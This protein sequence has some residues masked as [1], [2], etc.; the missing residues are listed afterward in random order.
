VNRTGTFSTA[1]IAGTLLA[2][3]AMA[4]V[5]LTSIVS[6]SGG[7]TATTGIVASVATGG[8]TNTVNGTV[9]AS[10]INLAQ[11][12]T[13]TGILVGARVG[14]SGVD[15]GSLAQVY[16]TVLPSGPNRTIA[17]VS[18]LAGSVSGTGFT[19]FTN[20]PSVA[21]RNCSAGSC[22][23]T[24]SSVT[25][26]AGAQLNGTAT[27]GAGSLAAYVGPGTIALNRTATGSSRVTTGTGATSGNALATYA[28]ADGTYRIEYDYLNF[29]SPSFSGLSVVSSLNLNFG[30]VPF[31][32]PS[33]LNFTLHNIG[34]M[35]SAGT[36]LTSITRDFN[37]T[38]FTSTVTPFVNL[39]GGNSLTYSVTFAATQFG[40]QQDV[41]RFAFADYAPDGIGGRTYALDLNVVGETVVPEPETWAMLVL[42]FGLIGVAARR[43]KGAVAA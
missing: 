36:S 42:G 9:S 31:G 7:R 4:A 27:V 3:S 19:S 43:H 40:L 5:P 32:N 38:Q 17:A 15:T 39:A 30:A 6:V 20:A 23:P 41:F 2:T 28:F 14:V 34:D 11:F 16:G 21:T 22:T 12:N 10:N 24:P 13:G 35:N 33:T 37:N 1:L 18:T 25:A 26:V 8:A 29:S